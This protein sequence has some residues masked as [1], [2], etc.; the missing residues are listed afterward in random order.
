MGDEM[1]ICGD[2]FHPILL[3]LWGLSF[4]Y[5]SSLFNSHCHFSLEVQKTYKL[6]DTAY[7]SWS[8]SATIKYDN[9]LIINNS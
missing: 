3:L 8:R 9:K 4:F 1:K 2:T 7:L 5:N 6:L